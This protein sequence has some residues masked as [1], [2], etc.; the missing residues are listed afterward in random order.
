[1]QETAEALSHVYLRTNRRGD[2]LC[3]NEIDDVGNAA[4]VM[5]TTLT[6]LRALCS[7]DT[8][9]MDGT[10]KSCPHVRNFFRSCMGFME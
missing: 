8:V 4:F 10:F 1:M 3:F 6:N 5:F 9:L 2:M 7:A